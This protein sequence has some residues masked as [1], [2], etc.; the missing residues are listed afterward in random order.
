MSIKSLLLFSKKKKPLKRR[1]Y[2][3]KDSNSRKA[4]KMVG[5][6]DE[7]KYN[8]A[9]KRMS[10]KKRKRLYKKYRKKCEKENKPHIRIVGKSYKAT[11]NNKPSLKEPKSKTSCCAKE[12][13]GHTINN[14][15]QRVIKI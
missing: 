8:L 11:S 13:I 9:G 2:N 14:L 3:G 15:D 1:K 7:E 5:D 12:A 4:F 6:L 10:G